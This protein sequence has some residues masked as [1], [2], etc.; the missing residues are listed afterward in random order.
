MKLERLTGL[1]AM[2]GV[3]WTIGCSDPVPPPA[4]TS[5][6]FVVGQPNVP[7]AGCA[8]GGAQ[9]AN[10]GG[11]PSSPRGDPGPRE[12]DGQN[13]ASIGCKVSGSGSFSV[14]GTAQKGATSFVLLG[15]SAQAGGEGSG[16]I[17]IASPATAG[18]QLTSTN[19]KPCRLLLNRTPFQVAPGN[20]W[21]EFFC[22]LIVNSTQPGSQCGLHG[23]IVFENCE[24]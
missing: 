11:P 22:D 5:L 19:D 13:G 21:A 12:V 17:S 8:L 14:S 7:G 20:I 2:L 6:F 16:K 1:A 23:E 4:Q 24:E 18:K 3:L 10:I 9:F 15:G